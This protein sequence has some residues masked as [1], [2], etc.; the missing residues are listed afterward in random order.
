MFSV[1]TE[2]C[3]MGYSREF[4]GTVCECD[5]CI[6]A[7][8]YIRWTAKRP[9]YVTNLRLLFK[10]KSLSTLLWHSTN[11]PATN[12][13]WAESLLVS[14]L[15]WLRTKL[16][17]NK[18]NQLATV[19]TCLLQFSSFPVVGVVKS[20][21]VVSTLIGRQ[22]GGGY[23]YKIC[24]AFYVWQN[25]SSRYHF[26]QKHTHTYTNY[27]DDNWIRKKK[28]DYYWCCCCLLVSLVPV[29]YVLLFPVN[30][31]GLELELG[32]QLL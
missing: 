21:T 15:R 5:L 9:S 12:L 3:H 22:N 29:V 7:E 8:L 32:L 23:E 6:C 31:L 20:V 25:T 2:G 18:P 19:C 1:A 24:I 10:R 13:L 4:V 14:S 27:N 26:Q 28:M 17:F 16:S 30:L 11:Q